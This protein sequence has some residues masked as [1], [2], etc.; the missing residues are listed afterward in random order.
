LFWLF[1][2][3]ERGDGEENGI[4]LVTKHFQKESERGIALGGA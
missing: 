4:E 2:Y 3:K 1:N